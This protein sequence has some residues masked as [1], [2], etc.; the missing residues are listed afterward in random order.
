[1]YF[2]T[3]LMAKEAVLIQERAAGATSTPWLQAAA[4]AS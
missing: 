4:E 3:I 1:L 2:R